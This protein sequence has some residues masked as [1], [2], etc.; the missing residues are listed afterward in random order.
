M[1]FFFDYRSADRSLYDYEGHKFE[2]LKSA[3]E[4]GEA[5]AENLRHSLGNNWI[6]WCVEVRNPKGQSFWSEAIGSRPNIF[7]VENAAG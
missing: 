5:I 7:D 2:S 6:G 3:I 1:R 4:F